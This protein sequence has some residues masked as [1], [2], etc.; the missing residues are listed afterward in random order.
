[1]KLCVNCKHYYE[2]P[3]F[4]VPHPD[5][6]EGYCGVYPRISP[7]TGVNLNLLSAK[8]MREGDCGPDAKFFKP[9]SW[10]DRLPLRLFA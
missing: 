1:M 8:G 6:P 4:M 10:W 2:T 5:A 3:R 9:L 7:V